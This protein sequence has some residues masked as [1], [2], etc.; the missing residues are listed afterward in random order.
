MDHCT[1]H[2]HDTHSPG[3]AIT[4]GTSQGNPHKVQARARRRT[5][6]QR[7]LNL[8]CRLLGT[9]SHETLP[10]DFSHKRLAANKHGTH[11]QQLWAT[12]CREKKPN[13]GCRGR[14]HTV[15]PPLCAHPALQPSMY[16]TRQSQ[17]LPSR[18]KRFARSKH[19][20]Q[21][22]RCHCQPCAHARL[23]SV[24]VC[25]TP[26]QQSSAARHTR[27]L[28]AAAPAAAAAPAVSAA[29]AVAAAVRR[30][31]CSTSCACRPARSW[32]SARP[33]ARPCTAAAAPAHRC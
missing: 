15:W 33:R 13:C 9:T 10:L 28:T 31:R 11:R 32:R 25:D 22:H 3:R 21:C 23:Y 30:R 27:R 17:A 7:V 16:S 6:K 8:N 12:T 19:A 4:Q 5:T 26:S 14:N 24:T 29:A 18:T 1:S 20:A 2:P